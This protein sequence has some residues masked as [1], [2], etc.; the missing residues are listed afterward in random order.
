MDAAS[1]GGLSE[2]VREFTGVTRM[3]N[4][5]IVGSSRMY[6]VPTSVLPRAAEPLYN[7]LDPPSILWCVEGGCGRGLLV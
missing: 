5:P 1:A 4:R 7:L 6:I 3:E 2:N